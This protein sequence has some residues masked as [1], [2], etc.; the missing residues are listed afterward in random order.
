M[1]LPSEKA[2]MLPT[3]FPSRIFSSKQRMVQGAKKD[4]H[5]Y[6]GPCCR[7]CGARGVPINFIRNKIWPR[8]RPSLCEETMPNW[9]NYQPARNEWRSCINHVNAHVTRRGPLVFAGRFSKFKGI[10]VG[11]E[12]Y[13]ALRDRNGPRGGRRQ[14]QRRYLCNA[15]LRIQLKPGI[16]RRTRRKNSSWIEMVSIG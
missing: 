7:N 16:V 5:H 6:T 1:Q 10:V 8:T 11:S 14:Q 15:S 13:P 9:R 2:P 12:I 4:H 3:V